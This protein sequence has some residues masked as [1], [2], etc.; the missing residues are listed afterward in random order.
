MIT[1]PPGGG[2]CREN[3]LFRLRTF[4]YLPPDMISDTDL[5][6]S[7]FS[8]TFKIRTILDVFDLVQRHRTAN[9]NMP[10]HPISHFNNPAHF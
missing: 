1:V 4:R 3:V 6:A 8:A 5:A 9:L 10:K 7:F 2:H